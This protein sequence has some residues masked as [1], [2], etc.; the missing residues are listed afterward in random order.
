MTKTKEITLAKY[1]GF[2]YGVKRAV[3]TV[4][5]IKAENPNKNVYVLGELI[6]NSNVIK[7]LESFGIISLDKLPEKGDG[8][9]VIRS[10]GESPQTF[11]QV[12]NAGFE[13]YDLTCP[14]VKKVQQKAVELV[15]DGYFLVI[16]GKEEHPE[17]LAIKANAKQFSEK[18]IVADNINKLREIESKL[19]EHKKIGIVVQTTQTLSTLNPIVEYLMSISKD[20]HIA[21]TICPSTSRRQKEVAE[22]AHISDLMIIVG[23]K[24]SANTSHLAEIASEF[25][26]TIHIETAKELA[27]YTDLTEKS[28]KIGV[29][30]GASTPQNVIDNVISALNK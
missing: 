30:A 8:I 14:D 20:L 17:V 9:C 21:N 26:K 7:E 25:T 2:C 13:V 10:H 5:K 1:A 29:S 22:L 6:H 4:K 12:K 28:I 16:V 27:Q 18:I 15:K 24:N 11:E 19:K 23:S 3:D